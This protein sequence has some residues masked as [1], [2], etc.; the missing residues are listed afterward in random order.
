M[1]CL[2][3]DRLLVV[4]ITQ[5]SNAVLNLILI[6]KSRACNYADCDTIFNAQDTKL[7]IHRF[8]LSCAITLVTEDSLVLNY[9]LRVS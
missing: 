4:F 9:F 3:G 1:A 2:V 7:L 6:P 8:Y 5:Q